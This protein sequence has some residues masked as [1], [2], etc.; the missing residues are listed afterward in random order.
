MRG[1]TWARAGIRIG[2]LGHC[3]SRRRVPDAWAGDEGTAVPA[4]ARA[5]GQALHNAG[6]EPGELGLLVLSDGDARRGGP[7]PGPR[8]AAR[9]G[10]DRALA[11][12]VG[13][14]CTGFVLA[15]QTAAAQLAAVREARC[16]AVVCS[17]RLAPHV[18]PDGPGPLV[19]GDAAGAVVLE[20]G[21]PDAPGL[22]DSVLRSDGRY[23]DGAGAGEPPGWLRG[24][25]LPV[26]AAVDG[27][28]AVAGELLERNGLR[29]DGIDWVV[30]HPGPAAGHA[31][32]REKLGIRPERF[33]VTGELHGDAG[34][35]SIP[36]ALS[37]FSRQGRF[38]T[39]D[40]FL[41]PAV[42]P[43]WYGGGLLFRM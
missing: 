7:E 12:G 34:A 26:E 3:L 21:P 18:P 15:V 22:I 38:G 31:A 24:G 14:A 41:T 42:G 33:L 20:F 43:G 37:E 35:A 36:C 4:A 9:I 16:A 10:A 6:R 30:P 32:I 8:I 25:L 28:V 19:T 23:G 11:F 27:T 5:V 39:G 1:G 29:M 2:G 40:L 17:G 13:G